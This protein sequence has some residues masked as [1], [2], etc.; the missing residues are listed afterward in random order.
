MRSIAARLNRR[1]LDRMAQL[2]RGARWKFD[3]I[4]VMKDRLV[5]YKVW[6]GKSVIRGFEESR[7]PLCS[8]QGAGESSL[9]QWF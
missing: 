9:T 1:C 6:T 7:N 8:F 3:T 5:V 2:R 4:L